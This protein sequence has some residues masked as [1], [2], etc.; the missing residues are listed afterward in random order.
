MSPKQYSGTPSS[1]FSH[2]WVALGEVGFMNPGVD[3]VI[4]FVDVL[5]PQTFS[6]DIATIC[7]N[8]YVSRAYLAIILC[9]CCGCIT[10]LKRKH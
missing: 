2:L 3:L 6:K 9:L 4:I 10:K 5:L 7:E 8:Y 1:S